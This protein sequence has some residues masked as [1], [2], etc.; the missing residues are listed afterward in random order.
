MYLLFLTEITDSKSEI[1]DSKSKIT[2][3]LL[4]GP[5]KLSEFMLK[6]RSWVSQH[7]FLLGAILGMTYSDCAEYYW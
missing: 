6:V 1:T 7:R 3:C 4:A 2:L 5:L